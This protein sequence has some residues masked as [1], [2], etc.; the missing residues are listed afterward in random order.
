LKENNTL[1][2]IFIHFVAK[3]IVMGYINHLKIMEIP[4]TKSQISNKSQ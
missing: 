1:A 4:S 3:K 2:V